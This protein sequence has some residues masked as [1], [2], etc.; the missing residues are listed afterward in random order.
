MLVRC[1]MLRSDPR[2]RWSCS[3][4]WWWGSNSSSSISDADLRP[5][6]SGGADRST[7]ESSPSCSAVCTP[8]ADRSS[9]PS[10]GIVLASFSVASRLPLSKVVFWDR[11][12]RNWKATYYYFTTDGDKGR[13][14]E[15]TCC[16]RVSAVASF[17]SK[18]SMLG[19]VVDCSSRRF[20]RRGGCFLIRLSGCS[21]SPR[22]I[23]NASGRAVEK[24]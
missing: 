1:P 10:S 11:F 17:S 7:P 20:R 8:S 14:A 2:R 13:F 12:A 19:V 15:I 23:S 24:C 18:S 21:E 9:S 3:C 5:L 16:L 4:C 22:G 6:P